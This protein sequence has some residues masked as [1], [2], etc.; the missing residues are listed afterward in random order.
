MQWSKKMFQLIENE[1][2]A[3]ESSDLGLGLL[4][5]EALE[6]TEAAIDAEL[7]QAVRATVT[8][9][10]SMKGLEAYSSVIELQQ[11][12]SVE[13]FS[14][15][16]ARSLNATIRTSGT[17]M[18]VQDLPMIDMESF[19]DDPAKA[20][21][22]SLEEEKSFMKKAGE[23][24]MNAL[25]KFL[26][27]MQDVWTKIK[28]SLGLIEKTLDSLESKVKDLIDTPNLKKDKKF[29]PISAF[30][31]VTAILYGNGIKEKADV[32]AS[33]FVTLVG[34]MDVFAGVV[35]ESAPKVFE[36]IAEGD[37]GFKDMLDNLEGTKITAGLEKSD[38]GKKDADIIGVRGAN[39]YYV[40]PKSEGKGFT[41]GMSTIKMDTST[42][43]AETPNKAN[44]TELVKIGQDLLKTSDGYSKSQ[45]EASKVVKELKKNDDVDN[46][47]LTSTFGFTSKCSATAAGMCMD[48]VM[49]SI[50]YTKTALSAFDEKSMKKKK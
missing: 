13:D 19:G 5:T 20:I 12:V 14:P 16:L 24:I 50:K 38:I 7:D 34:Y 31:K 32:K 2:L 44:L 29:E 11:E 1:V 49:A 6:I 10:D 37:K 41:S 35:F 27:F 46:K 30:S 8:L 26:Q 15:E 3:T 22:V 4:S 47:E 40:T 18:N 25:R 48:G 21:E 45:K 36:S 39:V 33:T 28:K 43:G 23:A 17:V 42:L 9:E